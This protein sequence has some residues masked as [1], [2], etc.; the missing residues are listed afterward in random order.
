M[1]NAVTAVLSSCNRL[2]RSGWS[3]AGLGDAE[4]E[5]A[6]VEIDSAGWGSGSRAGL[7]VAALATG[8]CAN[9][10]SDAARCVP[11]WG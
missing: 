6:R 2:L 3:S 7:A 11:Q 5:T 4:V 10:A 1:R 8:Y 9:G